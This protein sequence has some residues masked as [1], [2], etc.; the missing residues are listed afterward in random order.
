VSE[1]GAQ[2]APSVSVVII[3]RNRPAELA[4]CLQAL[5]A[6]T[7]PPAQVIVV[8]DS[9]PGVLDELRRQFPSVVWIDGTASHG[10]MPGLRDLGVRK[11]TAD[12]IGFLDDDS[13]A[14]PAWLEHLAPCFSDPQVGCAGGRVLEDK[15]ALVG[16]GSV[17]TFRRGLV[18]Q[19]NFHL[20]GG[21]RRDVQHVRGCNLAVRRSVLVKLPWPDTAYVGSCLREDT[22]LCLLV[23][24]AG[25]RIVFEPAAVVRHLAA[26]KKD[27]LSRESYS[28]KSKFD[29][30]RHHTYF[31][32]KHRRGHAGDVL[33]FF[34]VD[35]L[36]E[37]FRC[38]RAIAKRTLLWLTAGAAKTWGL[39]RAIRLLASR[40]KRR[41]AAPPGRQ[42]PTHPSP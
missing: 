21:G 40:S 29:V 12:V 4:S 5:A 19:G 33:Y 25:Y 23:S 31:L 24:T 41:R 38:L 16:D 2:H 37:T 7:V 14:E 27:G 9:D 26:F 39:L 8:D 28:L 11:A 18:P 30:L 6:Q 17:G 22:D 20:A 10:C 42:D 13:I 15:A 1:P 36:L 34:V 32:L 35:S 3:T